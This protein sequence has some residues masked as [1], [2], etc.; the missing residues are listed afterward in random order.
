MYLPAWA[1]GLATGGGNCLLSASGVKPPT[2][3][4]PPPQATDEIPSS[5]AAFVESS[6]RTKAQAEATAESPAQSTHVNPPLDDFT[7]AVR[8]LIDWPWVPSP[9]PPAPPR[10]PPRAAQAP[11]LEPLEPPEPE[12]EPLSFDLPLTTPL[13]IGAP[14]RALVANKSPEE[15][16]RRKSGRAL[17][18][19]SSASEQSHLGFKRAKHNK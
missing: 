6:D 17:T 10:L 18:V 7:Q 3:D 12:P 15:P 19:V 11:P 1:L 16:P 9:P 13:A 14:S 8:T 4:I 5:S 2:A